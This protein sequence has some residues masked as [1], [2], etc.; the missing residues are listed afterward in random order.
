MMTS[1]L[2]LVTV[3]SAI[4]APG[5]IAESRAEARRKAEGEA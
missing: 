5:L 2:V 4:C 1:V 3:L